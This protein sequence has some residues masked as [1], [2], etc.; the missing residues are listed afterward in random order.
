MKI[1]REKLLEVRVTLISI[2][3]CAV[4]KKMWP[5]KTPE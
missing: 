1:S 4:V 5:P 3:L 2:F